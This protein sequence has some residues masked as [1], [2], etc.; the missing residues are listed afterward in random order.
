MNRDQLKNPEELKIGSVLRLPLD[1]SAVRVSA[2]ATES[3]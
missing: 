2:R 1:A 3:R